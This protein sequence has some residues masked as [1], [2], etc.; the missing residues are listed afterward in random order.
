MSAP[1]SL[2]DRKPL[3]TLVLGN[4]SDVSKLN[5]VFVRL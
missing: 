5:G 1:I 2:D 3:R 4:G